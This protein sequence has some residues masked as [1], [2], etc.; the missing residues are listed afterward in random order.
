[1]PSI[2]LIFLIAADPSAAEIM[3]RVAENQTR[4]EDLRRQVTYH[5]TVLARMHR[6]RN[7]LARENYYEF[8]VLP[9]E[10]GV[11]KERTVF[12][13]K[14]EKGGKLFEYDNPDFEY[15]DIDIDGDILHDIASDLTSDKES[16][17]GVH[18]D[19]FPLT[20]ERQAKYDFKLGGKETYNGREVWKVTFTA[21]KGEEWET[22]FGGSGEALIDTKAY[23]PVLITA[24]QT[25]GM[26]MAVKIMLGTNI[27]QTGFK[28]T[29]QDFGD[30]LWFPVVYGGEFDVRVLF[31]YHRKISLSMK[32]ADVRRAK[33]ESS[34]QYTEAAP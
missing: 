20:R 14:Y 10:N 9:K 26:P 2:L 32:N 23:Q 24:Y 3:E 34:V 30:G 1:M 29:Y 4:G 28:I 12:R 15:K 6:G 13:G 5:Q 31:G 8:Q 25:K 7:K 33:V 17:D 27:R 22:F 11:E 16:K 18:K 21:K 19:L